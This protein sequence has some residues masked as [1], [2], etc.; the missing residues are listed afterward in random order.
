MPFY[1]YFIPTL[2]DGSNFFRSIFNWQ[3]S[4]PVEG[5]PFHSLYAVSIAGVS[6]G[7]RLIFNI[8]WLASIIIT[9]IKGVRLVYADE[10]QR[11][12]AKA[13]IVHQLIYITII[14]VAV[15]LVASIFVLLQ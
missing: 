7:Y 11:P 12:E 3:K 9:I 4:V 5:K 15:N 6:V 8:A 10:R 1:K 14:G 2:C 13:S